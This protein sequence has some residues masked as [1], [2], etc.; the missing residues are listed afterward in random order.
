MPLLTEKERE[1]LLKD[2]SRLYGMIRSFKC[3][4]LREK[5]TLFKPIDI[6]VA[7]VKE[8]LKIKYDTNI[9]L[10]VDQAIEIRHKL[11]LHHSWDKSNGLKIR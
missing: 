8:L 11:R 6:Q 5:N 3:E 2:L 7:N 4:R 10:L 1:L 9:N